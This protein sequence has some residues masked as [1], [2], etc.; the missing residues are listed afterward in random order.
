VVYFSGFAF[1]DESGLFDDWLLR[2]DYTVA[3]F[4]YGAIRALEYA[5]AS[6]RRIERL[7]LL[8]PAYFQE[9]KERFR[10]LQLE[11]YAKD[12]QNYLQR[13]ALR[14]VEPCQDLDVAPYLGEGSEEELR[15]LLEY[16]WDRAKFDA[17]R[18]RGTKIEIFLG[19]K[20]RIVDTEAARRFFS[21]VGIC[22]FIKEAGHLL[23]PLLKSESSKEDAN[24]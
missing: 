15:H 7:I 23:R 1:R 12:P 2:S 21:Q 3:G 16:R 9:T 19:G 11:A 14:C 8:S 13:F 17:L 24:G 5:H 20:D 4:S 18:K 10:R 6:R 22:Y